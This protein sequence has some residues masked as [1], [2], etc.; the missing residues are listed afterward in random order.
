[1]AK[2]KKT[3]FSRTVDIV[4][5]LKGLEIGSRDFIFASDLARFV[6]EL[7]E[8]IEDD[9]R[10]TPY[11]LKT[12]FENEATVRAKVEMAESLVSFLQDNLG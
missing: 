11:D 1:M 6:H 7:V 5:N 4:Y 9:M 2:R 12:L 8:D 10:K 3:S